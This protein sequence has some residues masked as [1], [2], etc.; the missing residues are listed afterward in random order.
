MQ[1]VTIKDIARECGISFSAVSKALKGSSEISQATIEKVQRVAKELG[2]QPNAA[3]R[4]LRTN[5]S[6]DIGL[7]FED[8]TGSGLQHQYFAEIFNS[9]NIH[10]NK[11]GYNITFLNTNNS[12]SSY[13]KQAEYRNCDGVV[14]VSTQNYLREDIQE[15]LHSSMPV[16]TLDFVSEKKVPSVISDNFGG[17]ALLTEYVVSKGHSKIAYI[18]GAKSEVTQTR[19]NAFKSILRKHNI[20]ID[21]SLIFQG[22]YHRPD[23]CAEVTEKL[24]ESSNPPSCIMYPDDFSALGGI[25]VLREKGYVPGKDISI[26]GYDGIYL[27]SILTPSLTTYYQDGRE[28]GRYLIEQLLRKI[29]A[30]DEFKKYNVTVCGHLVEGDTVINL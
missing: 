15:L 26:C 21:E 6:Y 10:A 11:A 4:T 29:E 13:L 22:E 1:S 17:M 5:R 30:G 20:S 9:I 14:L 18:H 24:L 27:S 2:Y 16:C 25:Q 7:I 12:E 3:A 23:I 28:L 8:A 19:I